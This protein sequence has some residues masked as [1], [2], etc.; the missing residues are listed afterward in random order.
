MQKKGAPIYFKLYAGIYAEQNLT[1]GGLKKCFED[2]TEV[3][4]FSLEFRLCIDSANKCRCT[5]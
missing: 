3:L 2:E 1:S 4:Q 5:G